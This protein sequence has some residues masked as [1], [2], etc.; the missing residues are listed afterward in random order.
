MQ[1]FGF[2]TLGERSVRGFFGH[3]MT[4]YAAALAYRGLF[5]L[6]PF[7]LLMVVLL[8]VLDLDNL[9]N[10]LIEQ[11]RSDPARRVPGPLEPVVEE[12]KQQAQSLESLIKQART[13]AG[14]GLLSF[15]V[16]AALYSIY[17]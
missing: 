11:S 13:Q 14:G 15:G 17:T 3:R 6:F 1:G 9:L 10:R 5:T 16:A 2:L 8:G 4:T 7:I 12:G